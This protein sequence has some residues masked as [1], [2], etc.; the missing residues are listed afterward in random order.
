[1]VARVRGRGMKASE[2]MGVSTL[3]DFLQ[4]NHGI[5]KPMNAGERSRDKGV[6]D[7]LWENFPTLDWSDIPVLMDWALQN[8][9]KAIG[10]PYT[11]YGLIR[12]YSREA[13]AA[14]AFNKQ[15]FEEVDLLS[16]IE[17]CIIVA[18]GIKNEAAREHWL[19]RL[20]TSVGAGREIVLNDFRRYM[21][22]HI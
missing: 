9:N 19:F 15:S 16:N 7:W 18:N 4:I 11:L 13:F 21:N 14:G 22:D 2:V 20:E 5:A 1:M 6:L 3:N 8:P 12:F 17:Q 10:K